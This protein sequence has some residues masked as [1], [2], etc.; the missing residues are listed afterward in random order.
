[1]EITQT[2]STIS[3]K[4]YYQN[5]SSTHTAADL[6]I[7]DGEWELVLLFESEPSVKAE[8]SAQFHKGLTRLTQQSPNVLTGTYFNARGAHGELSFR[9]RGYKLHHEFTIEK[10]D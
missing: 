4:T 10:K 5:W 7:I 1:L 8:E 3:A 9:R 2:F 6:M